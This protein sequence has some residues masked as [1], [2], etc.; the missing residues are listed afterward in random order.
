MRAPTVAVAL[1]LGACAAAADPPGGAGPGGT[2]AAGAAGASAK[3]VRAEAAS[4]A[5]G[6]QKELGAALQSALAAGGPVAAIE[7]CREAA[8]AIATRASR[9]SGWAVRRV[10]TRVRNAATGRPDAWES[11]QLADFERRL[12]AGE[13]PESVEILAIVDDGGVPTQRYMR[14]IVTAPPCL[15]C[16][17]DPSAQ[18]AD[19]RVKLAEQYPDDRATGYRA[20]ELRGA[21][22]LRRPVPT[23]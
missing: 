15:L 20:G 19:L 1:L 17:G 6:F 18:P 13:R 10:G 5:G 21:F 14:A 9:D 2:A 3:A 16:H 23:P 12:A 22:T 8:P 4:V 11:A 7:V